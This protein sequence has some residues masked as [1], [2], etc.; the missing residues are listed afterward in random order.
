MLPLV[1]LFLG[2]A[3]VVAFAIYKISRENTLATTSAYEATITPVS[4][5][6]DTPPG[7]SH[8]DLITNMLQGSDSSEDH[9][10]QKGS[11]IGGMVPMSTIIAGV[12][13]FKANYRGP[14]HERIIA[15]LDQGLAELKS[16]YGE[17]I[18]AHE[19]REFIKAK[20][21]QLFSEFS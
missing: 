14:N 6:F 8:H 10:N 20:R 18:P 21:Q 1:I 17:Q 12:E 4:P 9:A 7:F 11:L 13:Q 3:V 5:G 2:V 16:R 15:M 19:L